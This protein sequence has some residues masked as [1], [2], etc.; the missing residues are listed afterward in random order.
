M[1]EFSKHAIKQSLKRKIPKKKITETVK[2]P[3]KIIPSFRD[4]LLRQKKF[5]N[6]ILEVVTITE[7][8]KIIIITQYYL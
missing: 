4:R 1:I 7:E 2:H 5:G 8:T 3:D 6:R